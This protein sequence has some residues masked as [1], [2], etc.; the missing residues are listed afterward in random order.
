MTLKLQVAELIQ[1]R[2]EIHASFGARKDT[3]FEMVDALPSV[4]RVRSAVEVSL[5]GAFQ[6]SFCSLYEGLRHGRMA[7][8]QIRAALWK[9]IPA[10]AVTVEGYAVN[11]VDGSVQFR[12]DAPTLPDRG[13]QHS[14]VL[15]VSRP[16]HAYS[17]L[18]RVVSREPSWVA[19]LDVRRVGTDQSAAAV[20]GEQAKLVDEEALP[21]EQ[22]QVV[23]GDGG[24]S[25][26][27]FLEAFVGLKR[28]SALVRLRGN[29]VLYG[30]PPPREPGK[31][32]PN[33]VHGEKMSLRE[34]GVPDVQ[35]TVERTDAKGRQYRVV[36]SGW[37]DQHLRATPKVPGMVV[38]VD[39]FKPDG[40]PRYQKPLWLFWSGPQEIALSSVWEMYSLRPS[41]EH[42]FH[43][44]KQELG[45]LAAHTT[46][47]GAQALWQWVVCLAYYQLLL[48]RHLV[49]RVVVPWDPAPRRDPTKAP[50]AGQVR[51]G[52]EELQRQ[53]GTPAK[54]PQPRG[55]APG[56]AAGYCPKPRVRY[57]VIKKGRGKDKSAQEGSK[58]TKTGKGKKASRTGKNA[59]P[60]EAA[61]TGKTK[62]KREV[63]L[64]S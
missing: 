10:D 23:V 60:P 56:R 3:L 28:T 36:L 53:L 50:A 46:D 38:R 37:K 40:S 52:W 49:G 20:A 14:T 24:Y 6:R 58:P 22:P 41:E 29:S 33:R 54:A 61:K 7:L 2:C 47:L 35:Q 31:R 13:M 17:Y 1:F 51:A 16:G 27:A 5:G 44:V 15:G 34:P 55:K 19:P 11:A 12:E 18:V 8:G 32:G 62:T 63:E 30:V 43:F 39:E 9:H 26:Q 48:A 45:L 21:Q 25:A 64:I 42:F 59:H 4:R 57:A